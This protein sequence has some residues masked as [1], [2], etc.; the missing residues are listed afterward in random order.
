M[1]EIYGIIQH[2]L[3]MRWL[4]IK[5]QVGWMIAV[6]ISLIITASMSGLFITAVICF[7]AK[8]EMKI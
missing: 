2:M 3:I 4:M 7:C 1:A 5:G 8:R 6:I